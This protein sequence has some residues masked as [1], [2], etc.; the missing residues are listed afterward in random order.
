MS[1]LLSYGTFFRADK[2]DCF[3][4]GRVTCLYWA[5]RKE[6]REEG[7]KGEREEGREGGTWLTTGGGR[8][9]GR[10]Y[11]WSTDTITIP[12]VQSN[13]LYL[14]AQYFYSFLNTFLGLALWIISMKTGINKKWLWVFFQR[15]QKK[16]KEAGV[17]SN[18][19]GCFNLRKPET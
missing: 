1:C 5:K 10:G 17:L 15:S 12:N 3:I 2:S 4:F 6:R 11:L 7:R 8:R 19:A 9:Y 13:P 14:K 16:K 18:P